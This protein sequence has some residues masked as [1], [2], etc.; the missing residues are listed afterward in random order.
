MCCEILKNSGSTATVSNSEVL[1]RFE[2]DI[3]VTDPK[4]QQAIEKQ[5][6]A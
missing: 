2:P 4:V 1:G 3:P 5:L 6:A